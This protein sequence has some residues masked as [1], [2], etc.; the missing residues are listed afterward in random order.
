METAS[1]M[2]SSAGQIKDMTILDYGAVNNINGSHRP[3]FMAVGWVGEE[4]RS[5][6]CARRGLGTRPD[7]RN[8]LDRYH[9]RN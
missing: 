3:L 7:R 5:R 8:G 1:Y 9:Y 4:V 6:G 2:E